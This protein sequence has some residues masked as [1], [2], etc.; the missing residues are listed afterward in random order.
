MHKATTI[1]P[2]S[3]AVNFNASEGV[4]KD[5]I[6]VI[7]MLRGVAMM[8]M[9]LSHSA[10]FA[11]S[12]YG[13]ES[14]GRMMPVVSS[15]PR[16]LVGFLTDTASG[17]FFTLTGAS[18]AFFENSRRKQGWTEWQITRFFLIR[19]A[20]LV[21]FDV[22]ISAVAWRQLPLTFD[23][24]SAIAFAVVVLAFVRLLPLRVIAGLSVLLFFTYPLLVNQFPYDTSQPLPMVTSI[25]VQFGREGPVHVEFPAL[26]RL[27]LVLMGYVMGRLLLE[28]KVSL[29]SAT[30]VL[31]LGFAFLLTAFILR[32]IG[33]YGNFTPYQP[34]MP[35]VDFF[36]ESKQPPSIVFLLFN[37]AKGLAILALL[38]A[39]AT[40]LQHNLLGRSLVILGQTALFFYAAHL[41]LFSLV[42]GPLLPTTFLPAFIRGWLEWALGMLILIPACALYL[43][44]RRNHP[45]SL[46]QYL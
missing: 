12:E 38:Q 17:I 9:A 3:L 44:L 15:L 23:V 29:A 5:R 10:E 37:I 43:R 25:L 7:D 33:G 42:I 11:H 16:V 27:S 2:Q 26:G 36:I 41:L 24:L 35:F 21:A 8:L 40:S 30:H 1:A 19:A 6:A 22:L 4:R 18:I 39:F 20:I 31:G 28:K 46:L 45:Q 32:L 34:G 14:Y 13:A